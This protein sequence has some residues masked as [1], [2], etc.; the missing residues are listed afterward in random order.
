MADSLT[1]T[2][3]AFY[4]ST[5]WK[6]FSS[7]SLAAV[8][9]MLLG[10]C[11]ASGGVS[12]SYHY[13]REYYAGDDEVFQSIVSG[14]GFASF[15]FMIFAIFAIVAAIVISPLFCGSN[16]EKKTLTTPLEL[17]GGDFRPST[18]DS[19]LTPQYTGAAPASKV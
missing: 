15:V 14:Y 6:M 10:F 12:N 8:G 5:K 18:F 9:L 1:T 2:S 13:L 3:R 7:L 19:S 17:G 4:E 16:N 11:S